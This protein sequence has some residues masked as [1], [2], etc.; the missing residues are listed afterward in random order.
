MNTQTRTVRDY[1]DAAPCGTSE[2]NP[3]LP[4]P[5]FFREHSR[6]RYGREPHIP[7]FAEFESWKGRR[8]LE[9]GAGIGADFTRFLQAGARIAGLD[10][11]FRSLR[12]ARR[13][14]ALAGADAPL[15]QADAESI[16]FAASSFDLVYAWGVLHHTS[17][18]A[19]ALAEIHRVL[20]PGGE[21]RA[22]LYHRASLVGLQVY[23]RFGLLAGRPF[24]PLHELMSGHVQSPGARAFRREEAR[25]LFTPFEDVT[26][27]P[28]VTVY[29]LRWSR[30]GF[31]PRWAQR[32]VPSRFGWFLL[33][34]ARKAG[35]R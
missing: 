14:A 11:S 6:V 15:V 12:L 4:E 17:N 7:Q 35:Q 10:I 31:A 18:P 5:D 16:P 34:R 30:R 28:V 22:M 3:T 27:E 33:V 24:A 32:L 23:L 29:D 21:C 8:V 26:V 1:W 2:V 13:N 9:I 25:A 20:K 19:R